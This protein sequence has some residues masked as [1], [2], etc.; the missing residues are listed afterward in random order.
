MIGNGHMDIF[1]GPYL[2][3]IVSASVALASGTMKQPTRSTPSDIRS[4][5][6]D[7]IVPEATDGSPAPGK[8][9]RQTTPGHEQT[10]VYHALY[11]PTDWQPSQRYP[12]IVEYAGNCW[13]PSKYGDICT[14]KV[15]DCKLGYGFSAGRGAIWVCMPYLNASATANVVNWWGDKPDYQVDP[16]VAYCKK[17][18]TFVCKE[19]GGDP[20]AVVLTGFSRGALAC[21]YIGLYDDEIA[22]RWCAFVPFSHYDGVYDRWPYPRCDRASALER[23]KRLRGRPQFICAEGGHTNKPSL[24][25]TAR[26]LK[27]TGIEAPYTF[28]RTG[29][30]NHNDAWVLRPSPARA[31]LRTW[32][33]RVLGRAP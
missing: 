4:V 14:G 22:A 27:S 6:P 17:T 16:T 20:N 5:P 9:V 8:R 26:Y 19:Y 3:V 32:L 18:I 30:R 28:M 11:L 24:G 2:S 25:G 1:V 10:S 23:L 29:F 7:L 13:G 31:A 12:V 33:K 15:D 21:N